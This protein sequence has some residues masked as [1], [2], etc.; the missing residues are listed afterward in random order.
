MSLL[1]KRDDD[2]LNLS[3]SWILTYS[4]M[5]TIVLCFFIIFFVTSSR[6]N[7]LLSDIKNKLGNK[8]STLEEE[9]EKL[10]DYNL[11]LIK[12]NKD[13][14]NK[15]NSLAEELFKLK[16]IKKDMKTSN[17]EFIKYL[18]ENN[19]LDDVYLQQ[20]DD[21]LLIRFKDNILFPSGS[22]NINSNGYDILEK[23]AD[24]LKKIDNRVR[25][26][27]FTDNIPA[28]TKYNSNWEL[29]AARAIKVVKYF[30][31]EKGIDQERLSFTGWG[32]HKPIASND[33]AEGRRKNRRIEITILNETS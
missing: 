13:L 22:A 10:R 1:N 12:A 6:E 20:N 8:V 28:G 11:D 7:S 14:E 15:A 27:G 18:R 31:E 19:L 25:V 5:V 16:D 17:E 30:I 24:K 9:S 29:S 32:E 33:T 23:V 3:G 2:E 21:G 26:V 4:D